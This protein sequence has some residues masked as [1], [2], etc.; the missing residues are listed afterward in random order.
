MF[1]AL[2]GV[3]AERVCAH[4]ESSS[5]QAPVTPRGSPPPPG[6]FSVHP[7][8]PL[9]GVLPYVKACEVA[10]ADLLAQ[11]ALGLVLKNPGSHFGDVL[12]HHWGSS[13]HHPAVLGAGTHLF[14]HAIGLFAEPDFFES[15]CLLDVA[16]AFL[17]V[18]R[19]QAVARVYFTPGVC[20]EIHG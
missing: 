10:E 3:S 2:R 20:K 5:G 6:L 9:A 15:L 18:A 17:P 8:V 16:H 19:F 11:H 14:A 13:T 4:P 7:E 1:E 12:L